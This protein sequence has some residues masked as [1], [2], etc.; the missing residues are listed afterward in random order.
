MLSGTSGC[1]LQFIFPRHQG[2]GLWVGSEPRRRPS[3]RERAAALT[4]LARGSCACANPHAYLNLHITRVTLDTLIV[5]SGL[6]ATAL[7]TQA[8]AGLRSTEGISASCC[9]QCAKLLYKVHPLT[10][11]RCAWCCARCLLASA[12]GPPVHAQPRG[13]LQH[14]QH[15]AVALVCTADCTMRALLFVGS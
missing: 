7:H 15:A 10:A 4:C 2:C 1:I 13:P 3:V 9:G 5:R 14:P 8:L 12:T 11:L 6:A